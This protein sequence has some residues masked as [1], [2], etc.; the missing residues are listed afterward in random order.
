MS[1]S[2]ETTSS[3]LWIVAGVNISHGDFDRKDRA[4]SGQIRCRERAAVLGD[5]AMTQR[6]PNAMTFR[7]GGEKGN[8]DLLQPVRGDAGAAV[9]YFDHCE[10]T[11]TRAPDNDSAFGLFRW[12]CLASVA[13]QI[14][15]RRSQHPFID[16][17]GQRFRPAAHNHQLN[18]QLLKQR[19]QL[20]RAI[21]NQSA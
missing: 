3:S 14:Q 8:E 1:S 7:F 15:Q 5:Y 10:L 9:A 21:R 16:A 12:D 17:Y 6:E 11:T 2:C 13:H 19:L 18:V 4:A 20:R